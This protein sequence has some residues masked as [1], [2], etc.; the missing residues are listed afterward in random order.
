MRI[1]IISAKGSLDDKVSGLDPART[2]IC[3]AFSLTG[4]RGAPPGLGATQTGQGTGLLTI[5]TRIVP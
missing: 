2:I 3:P 5:G 1:I 4:T